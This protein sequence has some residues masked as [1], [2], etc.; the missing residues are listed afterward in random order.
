MTT[1][2]CPICDQPVEFEVA[3]A[4]FACDGCRVHVEIAP[5]PAAGV[6]AAVA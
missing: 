2:D 3:S 5:D 4:E 6:L 1:V